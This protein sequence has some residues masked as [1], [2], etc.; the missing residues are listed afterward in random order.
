MVQFRYLSLY[1][2]IEIVSCLLLQWTARMDMDCKLITLGRP[3]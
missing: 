3:F 1:L 2:G